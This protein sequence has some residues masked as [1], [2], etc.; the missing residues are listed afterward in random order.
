[1][2][3][4]W[5]SEPSIGGNVVEWRT[6][7]RQAAHRLPLPD[8]LHPLLKSALDSRG[9]SSLYSHQ[10]RAWEQ[11]QLGKNLVVVTGTASG[12]T[13]CYNLPVL[14]SLLQNSQ[15][16]ALYMFPTK[17]LAQDQ[18]EGLAEMANLISA[19][20]GQQNSLY[21][22]HAAVYD[23]DTP[24]AHRKPIREKARLIITNPDML[25][26]GILPHHTAW[27]EFFRSLQYVI[28]D[29]IHVYRGVF[30]SHV[31][32]VVRRLKRVARSYGSFPQFILTSATIGNPQELAER[33]IED[34]AVLVDNDGSARGE[35][36]FLIYNPPIVDRDLGL[37]RSVLQ[38]SVRLAESLVADGVQTILFGRTRRSVE[39]L[40]AYL[41]GRAL[42]LSRDSAPSAS[43]GGGLPASAD[44]IRAYRSGYLPK[45]RR[46]IE[47]G[48]K[49]GEVRAV[50]ATT[51]LELGIDIGGMGAAILAG[52]PGTIAGTWQQAGRA[53]RGEQASLAVLLTSADPLD[54]FLAHHPDYFFGRSPE[55]ARINPDN[56]LILMGHL[57]CAAFELPF[58][59]GENFGSVEANLLLEFLE[60]FRS[61]GTLH[62]SENRYFWMADRYPAEAVSLRSA[63]PSPVLLQ[64]QQGEE[65][66][67]IGQVDSP[68]APWMVHPGAV[69]MHQAATYLVESLDLEDRIARLKAIEVDYYTQTMMD[70]SVE[71]IELQNREP[72]PG[73]EK[74]YGELAVTSQVT[75]YK[76]IKLFTH[77]N[78]GVENISLPPSTLQTTGYWLS[79]SAAAVDRLVEQGLWTN[80]PNDYGPRW[81]TLRLAARTR[82]SFRCQ[83]CG[84]LEK[85]REHDV[86][87]KIPFREFVREASGQP[88]YERANHLTN[89]I[90]LCPTCHK[91]AETAVRMRSGLAG[92]AY[93]LGNLAPLFLMCDARD[94]GIH[95]DPQADLAEGQP[96]VVIYDLAP[97]GL[98]FSQRLFEIHAELIQKALEMVE[99]CPCSDGCPSCVG[100]GGENGYGGKPEAVALLNILRENN[101]PE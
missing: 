84:A 42:D 32:N 3:S 7:P 41:R 26:T 71:L 93:A 6:L 67:T 1:L 14:S 4:R 88:D 44:S 5:R 92:L 72:V 33:L 73:G 25:H 16:R 74:A 64:A 95:S 23:G 60:L 49:Q 43:G 37:R 83:V 8:D 9:I 17:A 10:I 11:A 39:L 65:W 99:D 76:K 34:R 94:I 63:S 21:H 100:P 52:Y 47:R 96:I 24:S 46:S 35:R 31:A 85:G 98:G 57:R 80:N 18:K 79:I 48:L 45:E 27:A 38:E 61:E 68:S 91:R 97:A 56:L 22:V 75:G 58:Q 30:G 19:A 51:A 12:K 86:H 77:E 59:E 81:S 62:K 69:Y 66:Q 70:L 50:V 78:L 90:T 101:Y 2:L 55:H 40:L 53:G 28:I 54:Q 15:A 89:L 29:E 20:D 82:D 36:H 13:L 87:H